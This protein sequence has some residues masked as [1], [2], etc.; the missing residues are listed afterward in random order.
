MNV[1]VYVYSVWLVDVFVGDF[2]V[3]CMVCICFSFVLS[4]TALSAE[5]SCKK[6]LQEQRVTCGIAARPDRD[7]TLANDDRCLL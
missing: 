3:C 7:T 1:S 2:F 4:R 6:W 5:P